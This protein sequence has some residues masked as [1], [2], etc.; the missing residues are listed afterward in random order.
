[1]LPLVK[2]RRPGNEVRTAASPDAPSDLVPAIDSRG[3]CEP[4]SA[5][6]FHA[7]TGPS[8]RHHLLSKSYTPQHSPQRTSKLATINPKLCP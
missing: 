5:G 1:V 6:L 8:P 7:M 4:A 3:G 2:V